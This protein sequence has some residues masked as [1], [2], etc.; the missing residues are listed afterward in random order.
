MGALKK[1]RHQLSILQKVVDSP[2]HRSRLELLSA[3]TELWSGQEDERLSGK[4]LRNLRL[5]WKKVD[6]YNLEIMTEASYLAY[7]W[8]EERIADMPLALRNLEKNLSRLF[9][10]RHSAWTTY[11]VYKILLHTIIY[12]AQN[13]YIL[14]L[15]DQIDKANLTSKLK[16]TLYIQATKGFCYIH[17]G[18][19][20]RG[21]RY[22]ES[23]LD[24]FEKHFGSSS[25]LTLQFGVK[26][27]NLLWDNNQF[28][29]AHNLAHRLHKICNK[30]LGSRSKITIRYRILLAKCMMRMR[31]TTDALNLLNT[32]LNTLNLNKQIRLSAE[33]HLQLGR[34]F[35]EKDHYIESE[36][37]LNSGRSI[38]SRHFPPTIV[39]LWSS[40]AWQSFLEIEKIVAI[41]QL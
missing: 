18:E 20:G 14:P 34:L 41:K 36:K 11:H 33:I 27:G 29:I 2:N 5:K 4:K 24:L 12:E 32:N 39:S 21:L 40:S 9:N 10:S 19:T 8:R 35:L 16:S 26:L 17:K 38:A 7:L 1:S 22:L 6:N 3:I 23:A 13:R 37:Q 28:T 30:T 25:P 15:F 31:R